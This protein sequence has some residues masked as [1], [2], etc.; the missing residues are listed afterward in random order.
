VNDV[1]NLC[2]VKT[3]RLTF[4]EVLGEALKQVVVRGALDLEQLDKP[5]VVQI[6]DVLASVEVT[7]KR[8]VDEKVIFEGRIELKI[9]YES[10]EPG[11]PLRVVSQTLHFSDFVDIE[12][13]VPDAQVFLRAVIEDVDVNILSPTKLST[14]VVVQ[15]FVKVVQERVLKVVTDVV[16]PE[17]IVVEHEILKTRT[18][19]ASERK[20]LSIRE[21]INL[22]DLDKPPFVQLIDTLAVAEITEKR[23]IEDKVLFEGEVEVKVLYETPDQF[24][25]VVSQVVPFS[26]F[27]PLPGA[28]PGMD[29]EI[30]VDVEHVSIEAEDTDNDGDKETITKTIVLAV[31]AR[32]FATIEARVVVDVSG[33][34]GVEVTRDLV[35][36]EEVIGEGRSQVLVR[37]LLSPELEEKPCVVQVID[38]R[39]IPTITDVTLIRN[40]V[41]VQGDVELKAIYESEDQ[42]ARVIRGTFSFETFIEVPGAVPDGTA[43]ASVDVVDVSCRIAGAN[44]TDDEECPPIEVAA[45]LE[46][47][48]RVVAGRQIG[49]VVA[50]FCPPKVVGICEAVITGQRVNVR[51]GPGLNFRVITQLCRGA[52]VTLLAEVGDWRKILVPAPD[53]FTGFVFRRFVRCITPPAG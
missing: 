5:P 41:I 12:G 17:G 43:T 2:K 33:V 39:A 10:D 18:L 46:I 8:I 32:L 9:I 1:E 22:E 29:V 11:Q 35:R 14:T 7:K 15:V 26:G 25:A 38:C 53:G 28:R 30:F 36:S 27:V 37:R 6:I 24:V 47:T 42:I 34:E 50:V 19:V 23:V 48:V 16:G 44:P 51:E 20:Q 49:V 45:V 21:S 52:R 4:Q 3:T 31:Q 40:K 13:A